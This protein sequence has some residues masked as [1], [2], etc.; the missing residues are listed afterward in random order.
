M[1]EDSSKIKFQKKI[2]FNCTAP[3][4]LSTNDQRWRCQWISE[5][6]IFH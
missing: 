3:R 2:V 4:L 1:L 6:D 5:H